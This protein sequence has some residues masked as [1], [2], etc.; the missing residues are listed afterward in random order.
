MAVSVAIK[1]TFLEIEEKKTVPLRR[2]ASLPPSVKLASFSERLRLPT[3]TYKAGSDSSTV[4]DSLSTQDSTQDPWDTDVCSVCT[5]SSDISDCSSVHPSDSASNHGG[6]KPEVAAVSVP[7]CL[8]APTSVIHVRQA[9]GPCD[10]FQAVALAALTALAA[11]VQPELS[12]TYFG[13]QVVVK[14]AA[15]QMPLKDQLLSSAKAAILSASE[16]SACTYV[17]GY[18]MSPFMDSPLGF[19]SLLAHVNRPAEACWDLLQW[20]CCD[21]EGS[22]RWRHPESRATLNI[23]VVPTDGREAE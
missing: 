13:W 18:R 7:I 15:H 12:K 23:M 2:S 11:A 9:P 14:L 5:L 3:E 1:N 19:S 22:C 6:R 21:F 16:H 8:M 10:A 4:D 20:G 17:V